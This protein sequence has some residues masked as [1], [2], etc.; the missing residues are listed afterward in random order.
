[1]DQVVQGLLRNILGAG[2]IKLEPAVAQG[3]HVDV[4]TRLAVQVLDDVG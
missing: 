4:C 3:A 2:G 1:M